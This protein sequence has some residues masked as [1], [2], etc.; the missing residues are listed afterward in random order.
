MKKFLIIF[1]FVFI[2]FGA[3]AV[4]IFV[5][6]LPLATSK[7]LTLISGDIVTNIKC[8]EDVQI[9]ENGGYASRDPLNSC[10]FNCSKAIAPTNGVIYC[11]QDVKQCEDSSFVIRDPNNK[12]EFK[13]C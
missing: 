8:Q 11:P 10:Q 2:V 6:N 5:I 12:C 1:T 4:A 13:P 9:C 3:V 7:D